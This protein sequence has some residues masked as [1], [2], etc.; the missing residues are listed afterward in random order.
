MNEI[1]ITNHEFIIYT[2]CALIDVPVNVFIVFSHN[3]FYPPAQE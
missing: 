1:R 3:D 2:H